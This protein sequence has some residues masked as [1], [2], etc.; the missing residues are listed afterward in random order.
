MA[1]SQ[2][3]AALWLGTACLLMLAMFPIV[4]H[5]G[6]R[7]AEERHHDMQIDQNDQ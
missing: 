6:Y 7:H 1:R 2:S 4:Y 3:Q 5:M